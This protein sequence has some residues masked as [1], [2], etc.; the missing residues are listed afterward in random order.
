MRISN[1]D[2]LRSAVRRERMRRKMSQGQLAAMTGYSRKWLSDFERGAVDPPTSMALR[3]LLLLGM[4]LSIGV[5]TAMAPVP[6]EVESD[7]EAGL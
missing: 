5:G 4:P 2:D 7:V 1:I 3:M 6:D